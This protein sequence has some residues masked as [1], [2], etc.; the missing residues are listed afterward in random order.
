MS[1][2]V[3]NDYARVDRAIKNAYVSILQEEKRMPT[4]QEVANICEIA[5]K[6]VRRHLDNITLAD[7]GQPFKI[8]GED[9]L[10]GL[11]EKAKT[12]DAQAA[13][14]L[15]ALLFDWTEKTEQKITGDIKLEYTP[16]NYTKD[17]DD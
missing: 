13:K 2:K 6:T 14:L 1:K 7:I 17:E 12:G 9:V 3:R 5:E 10:Y 11:C 15:F 16:A 8:F 4:Q